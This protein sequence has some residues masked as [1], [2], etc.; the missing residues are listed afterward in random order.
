ME[1]DNRHSIFSDVTC[2]AEGEKSILVDIDGEEHWIPKTQIHDDSDVFE[3][4][5]S[6]DLIITN[7]IAEKRGLL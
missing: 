4:D 6:G 5:T 2:L 3:K 1:Y 7:W